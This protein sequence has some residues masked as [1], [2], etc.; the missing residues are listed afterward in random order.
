MIAE[1]RAVLITTLFFFCWFGG[2]MVIKVLLLREYNIEFTGLS[3][4]LVAALVIAKV[5]LL[6]EYVP[7]P[8]TKNKPAWVEVMARTFLYLAGVFVIMSLEKSF[9]ARHEYGGLWEAYKNIWHQAN[10]Y[11]LWAN[12]ICVFGALLSFNFW[13]VIKMNFGEG[14]IWKLLTSKIPESVEKDS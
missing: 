7:L 14:I 8:F 5:V 4:V 6:L 11:H 3:I 10:V 12:T 13:S 1:I 9:E 2:L